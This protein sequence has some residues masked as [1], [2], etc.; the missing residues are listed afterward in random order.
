MTGVPKGLI[1][2]SLNVNTKATPKNQRLCRFPQDKRK[3]IKK[4]IAKQLA[5]GFIKEVFHPEWLANPVLVEKKKNN[6]WRMSVDYTNLN[7]HYL[8]I[9][10]GYH[11]STKSLIPSPAP[12]YF[13]SLIATWAIGWR[14]LALLPGLSVVGNG[15]KKCL[16]QN[17]LE[18]HRLK[19]ADPTWRA[20]CRRNSPAGW[21]K[22]PA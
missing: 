4:E 1:E 12:Y 16:W 15:I 7:K 3:A 2:H 9:P 8:R 11:A 22:A 6:E 13:A 17:Q 19:C 21:R 18:L 10:L 14:F 5:A 20:K